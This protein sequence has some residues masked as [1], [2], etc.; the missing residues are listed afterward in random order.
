M[1]KG[2]LATLRDYV[3]QAELEQQT[4]RE[5]IMRLMCEAEREQKSISRCTLDMDN[6]IVVTSAL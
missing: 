2:K 1:L 3:S 6:L 5:T 4:N